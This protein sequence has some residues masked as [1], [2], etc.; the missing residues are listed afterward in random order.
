MNFRY[1][2]LEIKLLCDC[3]LNGEIGFSFTAGFV[4]FAKRAFYV[5][6]LPVGVYLLIFD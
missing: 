3:L 1:V 5:L 4:I 2:F 6:L